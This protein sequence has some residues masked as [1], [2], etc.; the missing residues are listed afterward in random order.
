MRR[1]E[2]I[3]RTAF[4]TTWRKNITLH[5]KWTRYGYEIVGAFYCDDPQGSLYEAVRFRISKKDESVINEVIK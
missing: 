2:Y 1:T 4:Y 5:W 3:G